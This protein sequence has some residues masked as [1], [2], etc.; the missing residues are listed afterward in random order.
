VIALAAP[1]AA[2]ASAPRQTAA[3][4]LTTTQPGAPA[5][6][7]QSI[8]IRNPDDPNAKPYAVKTIVFHLA[9]GTV[10]DTGA[11]PQCKASDAELMA[12]GA[13]AC[14]ADTRV[15]TGVVQSD[16]GSTAGFPRVVTSDVQNFNNDG[17]LVGVSDAREIPFRN[18][19]HSKISGNTITFDIPDSPGQGPPDNF[20]ALTSLTTVTPS[21]VRAGRAYTLTPP[22]CPASGFW[23]GS[24]DFIY[25]DGVKETVQTQAPCT[26]EGGAAGRPDRTRPRIRLSGLPSRGRCAKRALRARVRASDRSGL[27]RVA[28]YLDGRL[29]RSTRRTGF[30]VRVRTRPGRHR[31]TVLARDGAGN[32][33]RRSARFRRCPG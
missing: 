7:T 27:R 4:T 22:T 9:P 14:P 33:A 13:A 16:T 32:R 25:H 24:I 20:S 21:L 15:N 30:G 6:G 8:R 31:L 17:E 5:G 19:T 10:I 26:R 2:G 29:I 23:P 1:A 3:V 18:V 28:V 12:Q 11:L